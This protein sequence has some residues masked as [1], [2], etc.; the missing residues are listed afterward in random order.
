[1][2][3]V[4]AVLVVDFLFF[5]FFPIENGGGGGRQKSESNYFPIKKLIRTKPR[6]KDD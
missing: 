1:M 5:Y 2:C 3:A 6:K 4:K